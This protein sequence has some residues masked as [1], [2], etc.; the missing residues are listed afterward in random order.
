MVHL[1]LRA[2]KSEQKIKITLNSYALQ[3]AQV[4]K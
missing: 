3:G 4:A 1:S 2:M